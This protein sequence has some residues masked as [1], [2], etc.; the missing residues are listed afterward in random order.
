MR[1]SH[2]VFRV[3][4]KVALCVVGFL[5]A[6]A[7]VGTI[8]SL[9][10]VNRHPEVGE[11]VIVYLERNN[12]HADIVVPTRTDRIDWTTVVPPGDTSAKTA[13]RYLAFGWG[14]QDF[15]LNVP[16][17]KDLFCGFAPLGAALKAISGMGGTA[18]HTNY[19]YE[20][21]VGTDCFRL[22]LT[23]AQ[24]D[25]LVK[26]ILSSGK[27]DESGVFIR[28]DHAGY[29]HSDAFYEGNGCYSPF[30]TCNTWANSAL[31][32]CGRKCCLWTAFQQP[33]FWKCQQEN[34]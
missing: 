3:V 7:L 32:A 2:K 21:V 12:V 10:P 24:Y 22:S 33:I 20:P 16:Q 15:Y 11:D 26:Y 28:I 9:I 18:L 30:F 6:Y 14:S 1:K 34:Q 13:R 8:L 19:Q 5:V 31:K 23:S 27:R 29:A 25:A 4:G 17:W